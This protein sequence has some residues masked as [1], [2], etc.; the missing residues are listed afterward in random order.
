V[1]GVNGCKAAMSWS[2]ISL[3]LRC[4]RDAGHVGL[5]KDRLGLWWASTDNRSVSGDGLT[6]GRP[7]GQGVTT[8]GSPTSK[9]QGECA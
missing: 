4:Y 9:P 2:G 8:H 6:Y 3:I 7:P 1:G 5:H